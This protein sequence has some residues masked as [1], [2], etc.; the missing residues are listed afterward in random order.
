[1]TVTPDARVRELL[2][3]WTQPDLDLAGL[4]CDRHPADAVAFTI[5]Q[6]DLSSVDLTYGELGERS[7]RAA[8]ALAAMDVRPGDRVATLMG[9]SEAYVV[10]V[11]G[12]WRAGAVHVP[13]FTAFAPPA[14]ALR[15]EGSAAKVVVCDAG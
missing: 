14:I 15:L 5:V 10:T 13:L 11:L 7:R 8:A 4:L 2:D 6:Q 12:L 9:K 3:T 1:M